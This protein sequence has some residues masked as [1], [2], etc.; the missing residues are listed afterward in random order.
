[1]SDTRQE[2]SSPEVKGDKALQA[3][4]VLRDMDSKTNKLNKEAKVVG[5]YNGNTN[6]DNYQ[7][8]VIANLGVMAE[9]LNILR[10]GDDKNSALDISFGQYASQKLGISCDEKGSVN[11]LLQYLGLTGQTTIAKLQTMPQF[12][13][14]FTWLVPEVIRDAI[15]TGYI[16][17]P[18]WD[19]ITAS[20]TMV[21]NTLI[22]TPQI[23]FPNIP[24]P[25]LNEGQTIP[26]GNI[27]FA[28]KIINIFKVG[29]GFEIS[30]E[31]RM[32]TSIDTLSEYFSAVGINLTQRLDALAVLTLINGD[33][34]G[35]NAAPIIGVENIGSFDY[36]NDLLRTVIRMALLNYNT[37]SILANEKPARE[38]LT[39]PEIKGFDGTATLGGATFQTGNG[40]VPTQFRMYPSA[41]MPVDDQLMFLDPTRALQKFTARP[42]F[43]EMERKA[44]TQMSQSYATITTGFGKFMDDASIIVD[45]S[46]AFAANGFPASMDAIGSYATG[47]DN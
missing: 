4:I 11:N 23:K 5:N 43:I 14:D 25:K 12:N 10:H 8:A 2:L 47:F 30:D 6:F 35:N 42:L 41:V 22:K 44:S 45:K 1:M 46:L 39:M 3:A 29:T 13:D 20:D 24:M 16:T 38:F 28:Q 18:I 37:S 19:S 31:V 15:R 9:E 26:L 33:A 40:G 21:S 34:N 32:Y 36:D 27:E 7:G 17:N